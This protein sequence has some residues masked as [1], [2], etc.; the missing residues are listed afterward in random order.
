MKKGVEKTS[1]I[2]DDGKVGERINYIVDE[3]D[4]A[5]VDWASFILE[6]LS[7]KI[8]WA[9]QKTELAE[10]LKYRDTN[11]LRKVLKEIL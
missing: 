6:S 9:K 2:K 7:D 8:V 11:K 1:Y 5:I 10:A 3:S 4:Q